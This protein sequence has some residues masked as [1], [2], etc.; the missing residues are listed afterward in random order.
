MSLGRIS[1]EDFDSSVKGPKPQSTDFRAGFAEGHAAAMAEI[2]AQQAQ[3]SDEISNLLQDLRFGY[4][5]ARQHILSQLAPILSQVAEAVLPSVLQETFALHLADYVEMVARD[6]TGAPLE[7]A[8]PQ[9]I[10][11]RLAETTV[12]QSQ[13]VCVKGRADLSDG[14]AL[15]VGGGTPVLLDL[16]NLLTELQTALRGLEGQERTLSHG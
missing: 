9:Q 10:L 1:L 16:S 14:Q 13:G 7:I 5:E 12:F 4:E 2:A 8:V 11:E 6:G 15:I 3:A